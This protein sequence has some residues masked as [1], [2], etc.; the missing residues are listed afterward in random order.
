[1]AEK[2]YFTFGV[3]PVVKSEKSWV[4]QAGQHGRSYLWKIA[5]VPGDCPGLVSAG[6]MG[7]FGIVFDFGMKRIRSSGV[8]RKMTHTESG[9]P[10]LQ[11]LTGMTRNPQADTYYIGDSEEEVE[12]DS[13]GQ[14]SERGILIYYTETV[15]EEELR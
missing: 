2:Q 3:G 12:A 4:Y 14:E 13:S 9:H 1:M 15:V 11:F 6:D 8:D 5:E 10:T 7:R